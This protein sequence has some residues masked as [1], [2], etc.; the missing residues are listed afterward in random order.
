[1]KR[2]FVAMLVFMVVAIS[3]AQVYLPRNETVYI[4]GAVWGPATTWNLYSPQYTWGTRQFLYLPLF[5]YN[6]AKDA[7][8]PV[9]GESY[10]FMD[11]KT[12]WV[13]IRKEA[14]WSDGK[15]ITAQDVVY[16][17]NLDKKLGLGPNAGWESYIESVRAVNDKIVEFKAKAGALNYFQFLSY[18]LGALAVPSHV[19]SKLEKS[20][21]KIKD[22]KNGDPEKQV[23]SGP[24]K[25]F[26]SDPNIVVYKRIEN[27]W[28]K[29]VFGLPRPKYIAHVIYK[30][31]PSASL[32]LERGNAD[33]TGLF[34]PS[35]WEMWGKKKKPIGTWF[36][37][38]PYFMP[39]GVGL[40]Y[41][42][43]TKPLLNDINVKKAIAYAI[44]Y[45]EML[46]KA[47]FGYGKQAHPSMVIDVFE[48]YKKYINSDL[49]KRVWESEDGRIKTNLEKANE[50]LDKAGFKRGKDGIRIS[51]DGKRL[52]T[53][54]L[55]VPYGWTD[56]MMMCQMISKNLKKIGID[57]K[58]QF[59]D[60]TVWWDRLTKGEFDMVI[61]WS[62]GPGFSHPFN[63]YR[64]VLDYR[65]S[66]P[67]GV[68][69]PAGDWERYKND[70]IIKLLDKAVSTLDL[71]ERKK[72]YFEIQKIIYQDLPAIPMFYTAH[73]YEY[74]E[75]VWANWPNE[76]NPW[77]YPVAPW[78]NYAWSLPVLFGIYN[79]GNPQPLP[80]WIKPHD[81][82][83]MMISTAKIFED[84]KR[85]SK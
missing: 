44:P 27:W 31:N 40:L 8:L 35:V 18:S 59:P 6:I 1:M 78:Q 48:T 45:T 25:L 65:L 36:K 56:W 11:D 30:D 19:Y 26:H 46:K 69:K 84:L 28:G 38:P 21:A 34:I 67:T 15:P 9:V 13:K 17:F 70:K 75:S 74:N 3:I 82:G 57:V 41:I 61:S 64:V 54:T 10:T 58:T 2:L 7:W 62:S 53:F 81:E 73:W 49:A 79:K 37:K 83:G 20:G 16:S 33:W 29:S 22:W 71:E 52:G 76:D 39:D 32:A 12:I 5:I 42:N 51:P 24:Y 43:N 55:A 66:G 72:T 14:K 68:A 63:V 80:E 23:V 50:I 60:F 77:W 4:A 85:A 47:Y